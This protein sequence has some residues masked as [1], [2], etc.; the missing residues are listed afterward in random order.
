[1]DILLDKNGDLMVTKNGDIL[2]KNSV[3]QYEYGY[4]GLQGNGAGTKK[5]E[6]RIFQIC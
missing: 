2:L 6:C 4:C 5:K 3:A 1:M